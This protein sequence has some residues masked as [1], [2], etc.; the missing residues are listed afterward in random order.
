MVFLISKLSH[1]FKGL[2][3]CL[4]DVDCITEWL[5]NFFWCSGVAFGPKSIDSSFSDRRHDDDVCFN[6]VLVPVILMPFISTAILTMVL[7]LVMDSWSSGDIFGMEPFVWLYFSRCRR[8]GLLLL[9]HWSFYYIE[10]NHGI[11]LLYLVC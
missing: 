10:F 3:L 1:H 7:L 6:R 5:Y 11:A 2:L 4:Y 8:C 9:L